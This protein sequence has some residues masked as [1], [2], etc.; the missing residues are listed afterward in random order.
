MSISVN[1]YKSIVYIKSTAFHIIF[2][3]KTAIFD[4]RKTVFRMVKAYISHAKR[5]PFASMRKDAFRNFG[6]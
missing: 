4:V 2:L 6:A 5:H 3:V 1:T